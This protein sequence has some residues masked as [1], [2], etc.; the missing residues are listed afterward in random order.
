MIVAFTGHRPDKLGGYE[1]CVEHRIVQFHIRR[2]LLELKP[3]RII[4]GM[5]LGVD[6]WA[7]EIGRDI[8]IPYDAA[9]PFVGQDSRWPDAARRKYRELLDGAENWIV[10]S[11]PAK[12]NYDAAAKL[13]WRNE[14]MVGHIGPDGV[15]V[16]VWNGGPGGT[17]NCVKY[18]R[19]N[20]AR[21][22]NIWDA[23]TAD[24]GAENSTASPE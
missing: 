10:I 22:L 18:A 16:A 4:T 20:G 15:L 9:I 19:K 13:Q 12:N 7:A 3:E 14:W 1:P 5:A 21:I 24:L 2:V 6:Q 11:Q 17:A 8:G 23:V